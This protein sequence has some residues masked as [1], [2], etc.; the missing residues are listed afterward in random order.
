MLQNFFDKHGRFT[1]RYCQ[2]ATAFL[3]RFQQ[4]CHPIIDFIFIQSDCL[5]SFP[6]FCNCLLCRFS[7]HMI[8][9]LKAVLKRRTNERFQ[10]IIVR[11]MDAKM[12]QRVLNAG[13]NPDFWIGDGTV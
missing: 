13:G 6:I 1:G 7:I 4:V 2:A 12:L 11:F 10:L 3:E 9:L 5:E 8:K